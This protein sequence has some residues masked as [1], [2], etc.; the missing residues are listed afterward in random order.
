MCVSPCMARFRHESD[1]GGFWQAQ[2]LVGCVSPVGLGI[3]TV[4]SAASSV[5]IFIST[6]TLSHTPGFIGCFGGGACFSGWTAQSIATRHYS[7]LSFLSSLMKITGRGG[8]LLSNEA[9]F[10]CHV[11]VAGLGS[12][13]VFP[14][15]VDDRGVLSTAVHWRM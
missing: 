4:V 12:Q 8:I 6:T 5:S 15:R 3:H 11:A 1:R 10:A 13:L 9:P 7:R 2:S 14:V